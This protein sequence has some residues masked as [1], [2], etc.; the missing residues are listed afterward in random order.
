MS[1]RN[2]SSHRRPLEG[3]ESVVF[4]RHA[5]LD[6]EEIPHEVHSGLTKVSSKHLHDGTAASSYFHDMSKE[7]VTHSLKYTSSR[8]EGSAADRARA[9]RARS[10]RKASMDSMPATPQPSFRPDRS[11]VKEAPQGGVGIVFAPGPDDGLYVKS[12]AENGPAWRANKEFEGKEDGREGIVRPGD[13]LLD[14]QDI[15]P[16]KGKKR[17]VFAKP[18]EEVVG[19]LMGPMK[20]VVELSFRRVTRELGS[21]VVSVRVTRGRKATEHDVTYSKSSAVYSE[22]QFRFQE[23]DQVVCPCARWLSR[24]LGALSL[25]FRSGV[26]PPGHHQTGQQWGDLP[27]RGVPVPPEAPHPRL[28]KRVGDGAHA[29]H[30]GG[31]GRERHHRLG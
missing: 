27:Q 7:G 9:A 1:I 17:D 15:E 21:F 31:Q 3:A 11:E 26:L 25:L 30:Q 28:D 20:S 24:L 4:Q 13:C 23:L 2:S 5:N 12:I 8:R 29:L 10:L 14:V 6:E 18:V 19:Y 16:V 22:K